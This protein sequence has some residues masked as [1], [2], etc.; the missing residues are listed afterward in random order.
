MKI[1]E[2]CEGLECRIIDLIQEYVFNRYRA[3]VSVDD[4]IA[5]Y[6]MFGV[7]FED[8]SPESEEVRNEV[9]SYH[10]FVEAVTH[11]D[12]FKSYGD[13]RFYFEENWKPVMLGGKP[14]LLRKCKDK[15]DDVLEIYAKDAWCEMFNSKRVDA[16]PKSKAAAKWWMNSVDYVPTVFD[17]DPDYRPAKSEYNL[18][19]GFK[20]EPMKSGRAEK[21]L[22]LI[23]EGICSN[24]QEHY[25]YLMDWMAQLIQSPHRKEEC[26]ISLAIKGEAGV[27]KS[28]FARVFANLLGRQA[29]VCNSVESILGNFNGI[30]YEKLLIVGEESLWGGSK[31]EGTSLKQLI[32][33]DKMEISFK[34]KEPFQAKNYLRF[35]FL[36]NASWSAPNDIDDRRFFV[37]EASNKYKKDTAFFKA[38]WDDMKSGGYEDFMF[39][40]K[41]RDISKRDF[42]NTL[43]LTEAAVENIEQ[44]LSPVATVLQEWV[45]YG[46]TGSELHA[47]WG[48]EE[49]KKLLYDLYCERADKREIRI[50][51]DS[52]FGRELRK[53]IPS[54]QVRQDSDVNRTRYYVL[55][56]QDKAYQEFEAYK[57]KR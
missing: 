26:G 48:T 14:A 37:L 50:V 4:L 25:D 28:T 29:H 24:N 39:I 23:K 45:E 54:V 5:T 21:Y 36:T 3:D 22:A 56:D 18:F 35:I 27:G 6:K 17:P 55:P 31:K 46:I 52:Q 34:F 13:A 49:P 42:Q 19:N 33:D 57:R 53:M 9:R 2:M 10:S 7:A 32:T 43:P 12:V 44:S 38:M 47:N 1:V 16:K 41:N 11:G 51:R 40:L 30:L 8:D 15:N 20:Y